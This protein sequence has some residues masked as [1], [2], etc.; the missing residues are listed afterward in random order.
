MKKVIKVELMEVLQQNPSGKSYPEDDLKE[1]YGDFGEPY[2]L[3]Y[4]LKTGALVP[5]RRNKVT[6]ASAEDELDLQLS[7][8]LDLNDMSIIRMPT[9]FLVALDLTIQ[10]SNLIG[11]KDQKFEETIGYLEEDRTKFKDL[12]YN[13]DGR[14]KEDSN[15]FNIPNQDL[16][17]DRNA[18]TLKNQRVIVFWRNIFL[19]EKVARQ[20]VTLGLA[21]LL[22]IISDAELIFKIRN[23]LPF[24]VHEISVKSVPNTYVLI[25]IEPPMFSS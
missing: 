9:D 13:R 17:F 11:R 20:I 23:L 2:N 4:P 6:Y 14:L 18:I 3:N 24:G 16:S 8:K 7:F 12:V 1:P 15:Y 19:S 10:Y 25:G 21:Y 5:I 22:N